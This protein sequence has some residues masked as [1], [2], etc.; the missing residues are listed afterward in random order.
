MLAQTGLLAFFPPTPAVVA[1]CAEREG[2]RGGERARARGR[3]SERASESESESAR[4]IVAIL[5]DCC[6]VVLKGDAPVP[7][8]DRADVLRGH[9]RTQRLVLGDAL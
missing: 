5:L 6:G 7:I 2:G 3:A 8:V 1:T 4:R 9:C